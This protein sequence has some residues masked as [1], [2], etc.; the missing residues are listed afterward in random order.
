MLLH[1]LRSVGRSSEPWA[2]LAISLPFCFE[3]FAAV[4][5]LPPPHAASERQLAADRSN[6]MNR[7]VLWLLDHSSYY[8]Y[9]YTLCAIRDPVGRS[10]APV[11]Q[12]AF[13]TRRTD[14]ST[15]A[16]SCVS[17]PPQ[18]SSTTRTYACAPINPRSTCSRLCWFG[19]D[20]S[21]AYLGNRP[22]VRPRRALTQG[23]KSQT[24]AQSPSVRPSVTGGLELFRLRTLVGVRSDRLDSGVDRGGGHA[25]P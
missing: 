25:L 3:V 15:L 8:T 11:S 21:T 9:M 19:S 24:R 18:S 5:P 17:P 23:L 10:S 1:W 22:S 4:A 7:I 6:A 20:C 13:F 14:R 12:G 2:S 16:A